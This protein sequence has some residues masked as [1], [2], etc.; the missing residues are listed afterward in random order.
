MKR[1]PSIDN[2]NAVVHANSI[3]AL[4]KRPQAHR[5]IRKSRR[6]ERASERVLLEMSIGRVVGFAELYMLMHATRQLKPQMLQASAPPVRDAMVGRLTRA[7]RSFPVLKSIW[8]VELGVDL[9]LVAK[10]PDFD[11]LRD[12]RHVLVHR[13]GDWQPSLDP[14]PSLDDR[15][16]R[17]GIIPD[18]YRGPIPLSGSDLDGAIEVAIAVV[19]DLDQKV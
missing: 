7:A 1:F 15:I 17:L 11:V 13:L 8:E 19:D 4:F 6:R 3:R 9:S 12:L 10:W 18:L 16:R 5:S 14:K 2:E